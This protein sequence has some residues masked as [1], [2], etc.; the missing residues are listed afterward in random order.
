MP[1]R[2]LWEVSDTAGSFD[3]EGNFVPAR[4]YGVGK[5]LFMNLVM[6]PA[7]AVYLAAYMLVSSYR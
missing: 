5:S 7:V 1:L 6:L 3:A 2:A 4:R